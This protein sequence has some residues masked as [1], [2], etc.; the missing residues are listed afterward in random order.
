MY[1]VEEFCH[2]VEDDLNGLIEEISGISRV[3]SDEERKAW[4]ASYSEVSK[5]LT[6]C[7]RRTP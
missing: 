6:L 1:T 7:M 5:M 3:V 2:Y 4:A